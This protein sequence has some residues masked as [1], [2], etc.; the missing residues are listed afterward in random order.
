[1]NHIDKKEKVIEQE[2]FNSQIVNLKKLSCK[3]TNKLINKLTD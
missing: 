3:Y 2:E 1:L